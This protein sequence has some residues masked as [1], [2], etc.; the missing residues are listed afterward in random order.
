MILSGLGLNFSYI[1]ESFS[2]IL[3]GFG[4]SGGCLGHPWGTLGPLG[5][6]GA[7][8]MGPGSEKLVRW[9]PPGLPKWGHFGMNFWMISWIKHAKSFNCVLV[10]IFGP[11]YATMNP[12]TIK[13]TILFFVVFLALQL[14]KAGQWKEREDS[15]TST[16]FLP[17]P[18]IRFPRFLDL[19]EA[20]RFQ[21]GTH[22]W[23]ELWSRSFS[24]LPFRQQL[25]VKWLRGNGG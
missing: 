7:P 11:T 13:E 9:T 5:G 8:N 1:F 22:R 17:E 21:Y 2:V 20:V 4:L 10:S 18:G 16:V 14:N 25:F 15:N 3:I 19:Y 24:V 6:Q 23:F 12:T